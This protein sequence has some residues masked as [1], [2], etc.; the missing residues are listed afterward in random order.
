[1]RAYQFEFGA[2]KSRLYPTYPEMV[3]DFEKLMEIFPNETLSVDIRT[4][5][6]KY[7]DRE[8]LK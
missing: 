8:V 2:Y 4:V 3:A 1:M 5:V 7:Y 6:D